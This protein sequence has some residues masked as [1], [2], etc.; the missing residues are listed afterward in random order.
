MLSGSHRDM[1]TAVRKITT[2]SFPLIA[3]KAQVKKL[4]QWTT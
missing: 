2:L 4:H 3:Y 1:M